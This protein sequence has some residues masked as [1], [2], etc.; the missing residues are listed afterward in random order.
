MVLGQDL[1]AGA[2]QPGAEGGHTLVVEGDGLLE[3]RG[4]HVARQGAAGPRLKGHPFASPAQSGVDIAED[5]GGHGQA[6]H[7]TDHPIGDGKGDLPVA[8]GQSGTGLGAGGGHQLHQTAVVGAGGGQLAFEE[9]G[10]AAQIPQPLDGRV[11]LGQSA[12]V[13]LESLAQDGEVL[14]R[15]DGPQG[16]GRR[17]GSQELLDCVGGPPGGRGRPFMLGL[18]KELRRGRVQDE[19]L[20]V[21]AQLVGRDHGTRMAP[22]SDVPGT[23]ARAA[24]A[25]SPCGGAR[26]LMGGP[27]RG[28]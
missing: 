13:L 6:Q 24:A 5:D 23:G 17:A 28:W 25:S 9:V 11:G 20:G 14:P 27:G 16:G 8:V 18:G 7:A 10:Q 15:F 26:W 2:E 22:C 12:Q 4:G 19:F 3:M 21:L 1:R